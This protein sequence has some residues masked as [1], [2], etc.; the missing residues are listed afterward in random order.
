MKYAFRTLLCLLLTLLCC[1]TGAQ[2]LEYGGKP[3]DFQS[4]E[5]FPSFF[6]DE[7]TGSWTVNAYQADALLDRF[8]DYGMR[9]SSRTVVFHLAAQGD[10]RTGVWTPVLRFYH[11][12]GNPIN[13]RAVSVLTNGRRYD[14]AAFS[15]SVEKNRQTAE[16]I[17]VPLN[18]E[19][20]QVVA[21]M[22]Q[23]EKVTLRL[24]GERQ[25]TLTV[26]R[27]ATTER[28]ALEG[29]S[30]IGLDAGLAL[31]DELGVDRYVLWD[32]SEKA[33]LRQYGWRPQVTQG[34]LGENLCGQPLSDSMGMLLPDDGGE[35]AVAVQETLIAHGFL[36][37]TPSWKLNA[38]A[39]EAVLRAQKHLGR[40][41]TGCVDE[42]LMQALAQE[43]PAQ[44]AQ[45]AALSALGANVQLGLERCW[46]AGGVA[47]SAGGEELRTVLNTDHV[48]LAADG[49]IRN[50]GQQELQ[51]FL[52]MK[53]RVLYNGLYAYEAELAVEGCD[54]TQLDTR[55]LPLE[56]ARLLV[57]AELPAQLALDEQ[58]QWSVAFEL[59]G[60]SLVINL[61]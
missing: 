4:L 47:P 31:L 59:D 19:G 16:C 5:R 12:D 13:A 34:S 26:D 28:M 61:K 14:L 45:E 58:A 6:C 29:Q 20:L 51:L 54:G 53:A 30:L 36:Y 52:Q 57:Y 10:S 42:A 24:I 39:V 21:A 17:T 15:Q 22:R 8:W 46:F 48:F 56:Q 32:L 3:L 27:T 25:Y 43:A 9:N 37:G 50:C 49:V 41:P 33:W 1:L 7:Q 35:A 11:I 44:P 60:E 55:L 38:I 18:R 40:V 23:S 2:G